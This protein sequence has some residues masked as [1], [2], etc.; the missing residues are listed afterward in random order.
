[1]NRSVTMQHLNARAPGPNTIHPIGPRMQPPM[2]IQLNSVNQP[3]NTPYSTY[4]NQS[5]GPQNVQVGKC[6]FYLLNSAP[7]LLNLRFGSNKLKLHRFSQYE[8]LLGNEGNR[9]IYSHLL[10]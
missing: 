6:D 7:S 10:S 1:M 8:N 3:G 9:S 2:Q 5:G 4:P